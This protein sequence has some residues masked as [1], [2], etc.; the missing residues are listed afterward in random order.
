MTFINEWKDFHN[1]DENWSIEKSTEKAL[2]ILTQTEHELTDGV[3]PYYLETSVL[4]GTSV[5]VFMDG[6]SGEVFT[7]AAIE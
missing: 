6:Q 1:S 4:Q 5:H 7:M 3:L 2:H